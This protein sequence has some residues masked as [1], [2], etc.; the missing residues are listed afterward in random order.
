[1]IETLTDKQTT[2]ICIQVINRH[3]VPANNI[4]K[5]VAAT[6]PQLREEVVETLQNYVAAT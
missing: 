5:Y 4:F 6:F 3:D 1:M 2:E